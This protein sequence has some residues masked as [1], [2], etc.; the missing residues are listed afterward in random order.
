VTARGAPIVLVVEPYGFR[1]IRSYALE[2]GWE[3][4][5]V[6]VD[7]PDEVIYESFLKRAL[8]DIEGAAD[9]VGRARALATAAS[10]LASIAA[11][12]RKWPEGWNDYDLFLRT[13]D[14]SNGG[15]RAD[16]IASVIA[17]KLGRPADEVDEE[18]A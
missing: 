14:E 3:L 4:F 9:E 12:E 5:S 11:V 2:H 1:Q 16:L 10:R 18:A 17:E 13:F 15:R 7:N 8:A 6:L